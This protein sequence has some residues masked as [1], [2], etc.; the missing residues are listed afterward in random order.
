MYVQLMTA[1]GQPAACDA[2]ITGVRTIPDT[3]PVLMC[4]TGLVT[5]LVT[6]NRCVAS[7]VA[8]FDHNLRTAQ[9]TLDRQ[10]SRG[11]RM[12]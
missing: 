10:L 8:A 3:P 9:S 7:T 11:E 6:G 5:E 2:Y 4:D 12:G 1:A